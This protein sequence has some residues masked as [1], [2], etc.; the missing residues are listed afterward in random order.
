[1]NEQLSNLQAELAVVGACML[2]RDGAIRAE[3]LAAMSPGDC[4]RG[5]HATVLEAIGDLHR[6]GRSIDPLAVE[7]EIARRGKADA[8]PHGLLVSA[9][10]AVPS[11]ASGPHYARIVA[12]RAHRRRLVEAAL[13]LQRH[14]EDLS[15]DPDDAAAR[16]NDALSAAR[17]GGSGAVASDRLV[18]GALR[19]FERG[20]EPLGW[21]APWKPCERIWRFVPGWLHAVI[22][23]RSSGKSSLL[24]SALVALADKHSV[25]SLIWSPESAPSDEHLLRLAQASAGASFA[26]WADGDVVAHLEWVAERVGW[27]DH[28]SHSTLPQ[29]LSAADA[30]HARH[31]LDLLLIDPFTNVSKFDGGKDEGWDR[32]LNR[33]LSRAQAWARSRQVAVVIVAHPKQ[34]DRSASDGT[35]PVATD[36]DIAGGAMWG[37]MVD[38]LVSVWRDERGK[39]QPMDLVDV[40]VQK[41]RRNGPGGLMGEAARLRRHESGRYFPVAHLQEAM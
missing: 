25:R 34:R 27:L 23:F 15:V 40:H 36:A 6:A 1:M 18:D 5:A 10:D 8:V 11:A 24:D 33:H 7:D 12:E 20:D 26:G 2:D 17:R 39:A 35:R 30:Y 29:I 21:G 19:A 31:G 3:T 4:W 28:E 38:S 32:L 41:V 9:V 14:A 16:A 37:N 13:A 22:G